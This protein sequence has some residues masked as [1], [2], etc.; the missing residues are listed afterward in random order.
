MKRKGEVINPFLLLA[1]L[2]AMLYTAIG[3]N[4]FWDRYENDRKT[5]NPYRLVL[6]HS[7]HRDTTPIER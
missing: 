7:D 6:L 4:V 2:T 5:K 1:I 3:I